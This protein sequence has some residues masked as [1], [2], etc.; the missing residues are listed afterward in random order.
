MKNND[1]DKTPDDCLHLLK[2]DELIKIHNNRK[3]ST[4][5]VLGTIIM[6]AMFND[7]QQEQNKRLVLLLREALKTIP[8]TNE[9][10]A[11]RNKINRILED[12]ED[13]Q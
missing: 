6:R 4:D 13:Y 2:T 12:D 10:E 1:L 9:N 5:M 7:R 11:L 8:E 3:Q